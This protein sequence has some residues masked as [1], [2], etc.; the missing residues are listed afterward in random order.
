MG[1]RTRQ[2]RL[3]DHSQQDRGDRSVQRQLHGGDRIAQSRLPCL[4][5]QRREHGDHPGASGARRG[6]RLPCAR[7]LR[8]LCLAL[9][10]QT[11]SGYLRQAA[12]GRR[13]VAGALYRRAGREISGAAVLAGGGGRR[14]CDVGPNHTAPQAVR[15]QT[16]HGKIVLRQDCAWQGAGQEDESDQEDQQESRQHIGQ[17]C[18]NEEE[19]EKDR[20]KDSQESRQESRQ[21]GHQEGHQEKSRS[22]A[23]WCEEA[24][25]ARMIGRSVLDRPISSG[26]AHFAMV[27]S[28]MPL[29]R[30]LASRKLPSRVTDVLRT[31]L[32]PPGI[33][34]LWNVSVLGSKRT[35]VFGVDPD[36]LYQI[37]SLIAEMP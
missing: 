24:V 28:V 25:R 19:R 12:G 1:N 35:T 5:Q 4:A 3:C 18:R 17:G 36:S 31:M 21:E 9:P 14:Q 22:D 20:E 23:T 33:A 29:T 10:A 13:H 26:P 11:A 27:T 37:T 30:L 2:V 8:P 7:S 16:V 6:L 15:G 34:Q 32:P